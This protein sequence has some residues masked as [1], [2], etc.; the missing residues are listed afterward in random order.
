M[1][2]VVFAGSKGGVGKTTLAFNSA[3]EAAREGASVYLVDMDPQKS[4]TALCGLRRDEHGVSA[5]NP[6]LLENVRS[7]GRA[8]TD[9]ARTG[10]TRDWMIVDTPGSFMPIIRDAMSAADV[11]VVPL[12]PS[13][14]DIMGQQEVMDMIAGLKK[15]NKSIFVLN[16]VDQRS[17][18]VSET[19]TNL[20]KNGEIPIV[21]V[22]QRIDYPR[23]AAEGR[24]GIEVS[25]D[26]AQEIKTLWGTIKRIADERNETPR[27]GSRPAKAAA[28]QPRRG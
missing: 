9:I 11:V 14:L 12:Q 27:H 6:M 28:N 3:V 16:R 15:A 1:K 24:G 23:A 5:D 18:L 4:L 7:V 8:A 20:S 26:C 19:V 25:R 22:R 2:I 10:Y 13:A 21:K 17:G